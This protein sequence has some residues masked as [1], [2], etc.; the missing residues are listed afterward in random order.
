MATAR[1]PAVKP[2]AKPQPQ[3]AE[4][5]EAAV[6]RQ[7]PL[8]ELMDLAERCKLIAQAGAAY[9]NALR[10]GGVPV[11]EADVSFEHWSESTWKV[12]AQSAES[13]D[14]AE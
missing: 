8:M 3:I 14:D 12:A 6:Q 2:V 1:R 7:A 13:E 11:L 4:I 10:D 9:Y 5:V